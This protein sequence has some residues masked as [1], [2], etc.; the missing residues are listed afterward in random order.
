MNILVTGGTGFLGEKLAIR[1]G[2]MG[3]HVTAMGRNQEKGKG[4]SGK[5]DSLHL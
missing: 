5:R 2:K 1:L 4:I 3:H